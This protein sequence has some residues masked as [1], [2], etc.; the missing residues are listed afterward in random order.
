MHKLDTTKVIHLFSSKNDPKFEIFG[1]ENVGYSTKNLGTRKETDYGYD[2]LTNTIVSRERE[3]SVDVDYLHYYRILE[4][5]I[6]DEIIVLENEYNEKAQENK[7]TGKFVSWFF[8]FIKAFIPIAIGCMFLFA[9]IP[10]MI[11]GMMQDPNLINNKNEELYPIIVMFGFFMGLLLTVLLTNR[12]SKKANLLSNIKLL[13]K[14]K[15]FKIIIEKASKLLSQN[16][17]ETIRFNSNDEIIFN[18][19]F[20]NMKIFQRHDGGLIIPFGVSSVTELQLDPSQYKYVY[21]PRDIEEFPY[22]WFRNKQS[23]NYYQDGKKVYTKYQNHLV[24]YEGTEEEYGYPEEVQ[25]LY[26]YHF[27]V[28]TEEITKIIIRSSIKI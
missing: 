27:S 22:V 3:K 12:E 13:K 26:N 24:L 20:L 18:R 1:W 16:N 7:Y 17:N 23:N 21:I 9:Y 6:R 8:Y 14:H 15:D 11:I 5:Q 10:I 25:G 4:E 28:K 19:N 2:G